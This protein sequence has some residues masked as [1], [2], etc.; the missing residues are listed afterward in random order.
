[1]KLIAQL[2]LGYQ[3]DGITSAL[4]LIIETLAKTDVQVTDL[5]GKCWKRRRR[6]CENYLSSITATLRQSGF[7]VLSGGRLRENVQG[8]HSSIIDR[9]TQLY[10]TGEPTG[11]ANSS[12]TRAEDPEEGA[13]QRDSGV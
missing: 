13:T 4:Y 3:L 10:S 8:Y 2:V 11:E 7:P 6:I 1:M 5:K 12:E 9:A